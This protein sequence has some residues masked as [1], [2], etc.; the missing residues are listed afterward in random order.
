MALSAH[1]SLQRLRGLQDQAVRCMRQAL[2]DARGTSNSLMI[3]TVLVNAVCPIALLV[4]DLAERNV[5]L[6]CS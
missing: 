2:A 6:Q 5:R 4:G 1:Y 3:V